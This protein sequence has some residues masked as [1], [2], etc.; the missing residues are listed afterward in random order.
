MA[1]QLTSLELA[2]AASNTD[3]S[4]IFEFELCGVTVKVC[5]RR[6]SQTRLD[7]LGMTAQQWVENERRRREK[8]GP[9][10]RDADGTLD[11]SQKNRW[12]LL[13]LHAAMED[14]DH[15]GR[16]ICP[17]IKLERDLDP[18]V[19]A[20]LSDKHNQW[21]SGLSLIGVGPEDITAFREAV[22]KNMPAEPDPI[23]LWMQFGFPTVL[24]SAIT[25]VLEQVETS[26]TDKSSPTSSF[27]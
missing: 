20:F 27:D 10:W 4:P 25:S 17:L 7:K 24:A 13:Q 6:L 11:R 26:Q 5:F 2:L 9:E 16:D 12:D 8:D 22:K 23:S 19:H 14:P 21:L 15:P 3:R 1:E 18:D